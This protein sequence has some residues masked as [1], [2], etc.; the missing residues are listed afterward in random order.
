MKAIKRLNLI[1]IIIS[2]SLIISCKEKNDDLVIILHTRDSK[3]L[4]INNPIYC[5]NNGE[6]Y[7]EIDETNYNFINEN[8]VSKI[9]ILCNGNNV[10]ALPSLVF[11]SKLPDSELF[12]LVDDNKLKMDYVKKNNKIWILIR[13]KIDSNILKNNI[14]IKTSCNW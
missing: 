7:F 11:L 2:N 3:D 8:V 1:L 13:E 4:I 9:S 12:F 10:S 14:S 6:F 5:F